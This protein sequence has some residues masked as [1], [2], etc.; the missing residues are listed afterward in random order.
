MTLSQLTGRWSTGKSRKASA[1]IRVRRETGT[2]TK[3]YIP[4]VTSPLRSNSLFPALWA[5][6]TRSSVRWV[7]FVIGGGWVLTV[8]SWYWRQLRHKK[9][10]DVCWWQSTWGGGWQVGRQ[11][12]WHWSR[13]KLIQ[14]I[15]G[16]TRRGRLDKGENSGLSIWHLPPT[17]AI[18][19]QV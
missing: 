19:Q 7:G 2:G 10:L 6:Q 9:W 15:R 3:C 18:A 12:L 8:R 13:Y 1:P 16:A 17:E 14:L 5:P 11:L 4:T